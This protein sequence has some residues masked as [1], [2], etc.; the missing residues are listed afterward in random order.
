MNAIRIVTPLAAAALIMAGTVGDRTSARAVAPDIQQLESPAGPGAAES[1]L[2]VGPDGKIYLSWME[3]APDSAM[4]LRFSS[5]DGTR[6]SAPQTI[7]SGRDFFVNWA[8][9]PSLAV[10]ANGRMAAHWLQRQGT[11]SSYAYDV[12]I[13][14]SADGGK[15]WGTPFAP[16][17]DRSATEKG[18]VTMW[19]DGNGFGAA[20]LD[21]RKAD[22]AGKNPVQEMMLFATTI[23][24]T[25]AA[26]ETQL[27]GRACDCCQTT[28][29]VTSNG[30]IIAYRDRSANEIRDIYVTRR[31]G[32]AWSEPK[33]VFADNWEINACPVNGPS[34]DA[35]GRRVA[36]AWYTGA[37]DVP[38]V[39]VAF[40]S[41]AGAT[42]GAPI[43]VDEGK[44]AGRVAAVLLKD[45]SALVSWIERTGGDTASVRVRRVRE[46][47]GAGP[48][49]TVAASSAARASG[50]P[51]MALAGDRVFFAWTVPGRPSSVRVAR[52][53]AADFR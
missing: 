9:F 50:F 20:W 44:P 52:A 34:V 36:L 26:N 33:A 45:G 15:T 47:E 13:A 41:D 25:G 49:A 4:A 16:H 17:A 32:G 1:N 39:K 53:N 6:W 48:A 21:G 28:A 42:F 30:P 35:A 22:K 51:R 24:A 37:R 5:F 40:S 43:I 27:D 12:R 14:Q 38:R 11:G 18:F 3:P 7:R 46:K 31:L 2:T 23:N 8:D 19:R 10:Q 29:A